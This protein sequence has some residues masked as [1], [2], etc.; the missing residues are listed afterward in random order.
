MKYNQALKTLKE[1]R[2][3]DAVELLE[4]LVVDPYIFSR[5]DL[6]QLSVPQQKL[7]LGCLKILGDLYRDGEY[8]N[9]ERCKIMYERAIYYDQNENDNVNF[10]Y[11]LGKVCFEMGDLYSAHIAFGH[12]LSL[13][14]GHWNC[15]EHIVTVSF[16]IQDYTS[17]LF[18]CTSGLSLD[19]GFFK[20]QVFRDLVY[21][22]FP[23]LNKCGEEKIQQAFHK[24]IPK[25][26]QEIWKERYLQELQSLQCRSRE[27][28]VDI[29]RQISLPT[30]KIHFNLKSFSLVELV[31]GIV[32]AYEKL[33]G[34]AEFHKIAEVTWSLGSGDGSAMEVDELKPVSTEESQ[35]G[36]E[37]E[38]QSA[39]VLRTSRSSSDDKDSGS[40]ANTSIQAG[41]TG[42]STSQLEGD[43]DRENG[44]GEGQ[45][46]NGENQAANN[47]DKEEAGNKKKNKRDVKWWQM[48]GKRR[49]QRVRGH[50]LPT[51]PDKAKKESSFADQLKNLIPAPLLGDDGSTSERESARICCDKSG[52]QKK[53]QQSY[54]G[55]KEEENHVR[56]L[57]GKMSGMN[58]ASIVSSIVTVLA[59]KV[60]YPWPAELRDLFFRL[61][62]HFRLVI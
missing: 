14:P 52:W 5:D 51:S 48:E 43:G 28:T 35:T 57:L 12:A 27:R 55:T 36:G 2:K 3:K 41:G 1:G 23:E 26:Q 37:E 6:K 58:V 54:F 59:N 34:T 29:Q 15:L 22:I 44:N 16:A 4:E 8:K 25:G 47:T 53:F 24:A 50:L 33:F 19:S 9:L 45:Q 32:Q 18:Y 60:K 39:A 7:Q 62:H 13:R 10:W 38:S 61:Y 31:K 11:R 49:S 46:Q 30:P 56:G 42:D 21:Q 40:T 20:G 17:C